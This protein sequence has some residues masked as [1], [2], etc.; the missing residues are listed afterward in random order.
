MCEKYLYLLFTE[1]VLGKSEA[2]YFSSG[3]RYLLWAR[4]DDTGVPSVYFSRYGDKTTMYPETVE[5]AYPKVNIKTN[6]RFSQWA[7]KWDLHI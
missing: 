5:Y 3:G 6:S 2:N 4:L 7:S 1:D